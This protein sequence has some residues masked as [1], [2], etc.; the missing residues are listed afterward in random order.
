MNL[1]LLENF[2]K[3]LPGQITSVFEF[4][5][6][7]WYSDETY[8]LLDKYNCGFCIHD[9]AGMETPKIITGKIIYLR[10]HGPTGRYAGN[11]TKQQ[12]SSY[13]KWIKENLKSAKAI[14][15]YFNNDYNAYAVKNAKE[16]KQ[17]MG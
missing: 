5:N 8:K 12:L 10:F 4:R 17:Q 6:K 16:L 7:T 9:L 11:Y 3:L 13:A 15:A 14:Y 2:L 1:E